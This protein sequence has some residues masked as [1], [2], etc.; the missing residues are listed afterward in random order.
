MCVNSCA[1]SVAGVPER[2]HAPRDLVRQAP[3]EEACEVWRRRPRRDRLAPRDLRPEAE[4]LLRRDEAVFL[5]RRQARRR[6]RTSSCTSSRDRRSLS[7]P[8]GKDASCNIV[9]SSLLTSSTRSGCCARNARTTSTSPGLR[10]CAA[11]TI[12]SG[13]TMTR[14]NSPSYDDA[15]TSAAQPMQ[16]KCIDGPRESRRHLTARRPK[17]QG[18]TVPTLT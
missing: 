11:S 7:S 18:R 1:Y 12:S 5:P 14:R 2:E 17:G 15:T 16:V 9:L 13:R 4:Q 8:I 6:R 3:R 10:P